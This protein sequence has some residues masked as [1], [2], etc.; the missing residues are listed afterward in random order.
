MEQR[1]TAAAAASLRF[2]QMHFI[3]IKNHY[4]AWCSREK[5]ICTKSLNINQDQ[6]I[7]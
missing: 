2:I 7:V 6:L 5:S 3:Q 4:Y 1:L